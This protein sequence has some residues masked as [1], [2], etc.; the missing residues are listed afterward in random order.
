MRRRLLA[1]YLAV[2][3][4]VLVAREIPLALAYA[5]NERTDLTGKVERDAVALST[6]AE[7]ALAGS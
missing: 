7:D 6:L 3:L 2:A 5:R 1:S 4:L